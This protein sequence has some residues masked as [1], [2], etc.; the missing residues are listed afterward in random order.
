MIF[1]PAQFGHSISQ[2]MNYSLR[3][4]VHLI[5]S[6]AFLLTLLINHDNR[7]GGIKLELQKGITRETKA[8]S[9]PLNMRMGSTK[10]LN[11]GITKSHDTGIT[12]GI[13]MGITKSHNMGLTPG[14]DIGILPGYNMGITPGRDAGII[15]GH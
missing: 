5:A 8:P 9:F 4:E 14:Q 7:H 15:Q 10:G 2:K 3:H 11:I 6:Q 13:N 12:K 1:S